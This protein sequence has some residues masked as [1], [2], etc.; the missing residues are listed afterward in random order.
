VKDAM[1][2]TRKADAAI[3]TGGTGAIGFAV[4]RLLADSGQRVAFTFR[5]N[6]EARDKVL[7]YLN[8]AGS[9]SLGRAV[10]LTDAAAT[11]VFVSEVTGEIGPVRTLVHAAGPLVPQRFVSQIDAGE[12]GYHLQNETQAFFNVARACLPS[13]RESGGSITAVTTVATRRFPRRDALS[14]APKAG[15]EALVRALASEEGR[16]GVRANCVGPGILG[17]G[18]A[19]ELHARGDFDAASRER[20]LRSIPLGRF[21]SA[22]DVAELV[23]FLASDKACYIS[24]QMIDVDGGYSL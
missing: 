14:S 10:D 23:C 13:L 7:E 2:R 18:M 15:I 19:S 8:A 1:T 22:Q 5:S 4:C 20:A 21:G 16:F 17:D 6:D 24:G 12:F 9:S 3:V 11:R